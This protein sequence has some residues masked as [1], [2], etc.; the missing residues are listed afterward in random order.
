MFFSLFLKAINK[1]IYIA[2]DNHNSIGVIIPVKN[3][4]DHYIV[5]ADRDLYTFRWLED[6]LRATKLAALHQVDKNKPKNQFNDGKADIKG[7]LWI[8]KK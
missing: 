5:G 7:R 6:N 4:T 2:L 8:G 3:S 1:T